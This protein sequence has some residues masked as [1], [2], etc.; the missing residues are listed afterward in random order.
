MSQTSPTRHRQPSSRRPATTGPE[1][2]ALR[3]TPLASALAMAWQGALWA[4][5][6]PAPATVPIPAA[7]WRVNG[8]GS[9]APVNTSNAA[10]GVNQ[11]IGQTSARAIYNWQSFD[12]GSASQVTFD[13]AQKGASALNRVT[14]S[15]APSQIFGQLRATNGGEIVLVNRNGVLF[16]RGATV[17]TGSLIASALSI[18]DTEY[19][20]GFTN[21]LANAASGA[22]AFSYDGA[23]ADFVDSRNFVQVDAGAHISTDSGGRVFLFAKRVDNA[24]TIEAPSGQVALGGGGSVFFK[25][26][27]TDGTLY[28]SETNPNVSALRGFLVEVGKGPQGAPEGVSGSVS[29][30]ASGVISTPRGNTTL[31]GL[32]VNQM[33]RISATTSVSENGSVILRAQGNAEYVN[34]SGIFAV[35]AQQAG[36]LVLG[37]GSSIQISPDASTATTTDSAGFA[38][39][40]VDLSGHTVVFERGASVVAPGATVNLRAESTPSYKVRTDTEGAI[41]TVD[42]T[43]RIVLGEN[44]VIDVAGTTTTQRSV[45]DLFVT[46]ELLGSNDLKDAP[47]QKDGLLYRGKVTV[48]T[49]ANSLILGSLDSYRSALGRTVTERLSAGGDVNLR[50]EGAVLTNASSSIRVTGGEVH[51]SAAQVSP[52]LL[53]ASNGSLYDLN[54]A[55]ADLVYSGALNFEKPSD[56]NY[57]R[58]GQNPAYGTR[59]SRTEAGYTEGRQAGS[60]A[61]AAPVKIGRAHV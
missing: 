16:G 34:Q 56:I 29:N 6:A 39:S 2:L 31:V 32:A 61:I 10:G 26:P 48:D 59:T 46:T 25:L 22:S 4:A 3:L 36:D 47:L 40:H 50:A 21:S 49:R 24:G 14:G 38:T 57:S 8:T 20:S 44:A 41:T 28:A 55:P 15:A 12:I 9:A 13:M 30:S 11:V 53:L 33:G 51:Y 37:A 42:P 60:V 27:D 1:R 52:T 43:A 35:R 23:A 58:W 17:A 54:N 5:P 45:A 19:L 18:S 7:S